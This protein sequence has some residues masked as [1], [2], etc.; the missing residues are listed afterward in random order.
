MVQVAH[1]VP[2]LTGIFV[3]S[4]LIAI[5]CSLVVRTDVLIRQLIGHPLV[6]LHREVSPRTHVP[7]V[8]DNHVGNGAN[9]FVLERC[10]H[11]AQLGFTAERTIIVAGEPIQVVVAHRLTTAIAALRNPHQVESRR[12]I[13]YLLFKSAPLGIGI[14]VPI[15]GLQH[16]SVILLGPAL[17]HHAQ[18]ND[19]HQ[20]C[21]VKSFHKSVVFYFCCEDTKIFNSK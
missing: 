14:T 8:V 20:Q 17:C 1:A 15:E 11:G 2:A 12:E 3:R 13:I 5:R 10:D 21:S 6:G 4:Y 19:H 7:A 9:A 18:C 16:H